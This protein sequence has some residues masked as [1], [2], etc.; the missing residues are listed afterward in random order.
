MNS[1]TFQIYNASAGSGKTFTLVKEYLKILFKSQFHDAYKNALAITFTNKAV[2]EMKDRIIEN[3]KMFSDP[4]ILNKPTQMFC[5]ICDELELKPKKVHLKAKKILESILHNYA[6]FDISTIDKFTQKLIRTFAYDLHL[7]VNFEVEL[8]TDNLLHKA[9]NNLI[10]KAGS[11][12]KL[13]KT[14]VDFAIEKADDDRSWDVSFD[15]YNIAKLLIQE[16][17][18]KYLE[19]LKDKTLQDFDTLKD[20]VLKKI[21]DTEK[22]I[23]SQSTAA[24]TL[25]EECG[26]EHSDFSRSSLPNHFLKLRS[27]NY[28]VKFDNKWQ[29]DLGEKP[30]YPS[31]VSPDIA[32][33]IDNIEPDLI[34]FFNNTK[35]QFFELLLAKSIYKNLTPLSV[36]KHINNELDIIKEEQNLLLISEFNSI[37]SNHIKEQP[38]PFIYERIGEKFKHYFIDEFQDTSQMQWENL[39]PLLENTLSSENGSTLI[40]GDAKQAIYRWRGGKAE[41]F[42]DLFTGANPFHIKKNVENLPANYR[43]SKNVV[44]FNN[45]FFNH[46]SEIAFRDESYSNLYQKSHQ[47]II[48]KEEGFVSLSFIETNDGEDKK[49]VYAQKTLSTINNCI[50]NGYALSDI[51]ILVRYGRDGVI[52]S[53]YLSEHGIEIISSET[54]L[55]KN[56]PEIIFIIHLLEYITEPENALAKIQA[57][58]YLAKHYLKLQ[59]KHDFFTQFR[60]SDLNSCFKKLENFGI[61]FDVNEFLSLPFYEA[62]EFIVYSFSLTKDSDSYIQFFLDFVLDFNENNNVTLHSFL[63]HYEL[64][65]DK[66]SVIS[67]EGNNAVQI[68]T[69]HK[70]KGLEFPVVIFPFADLDIYNNRKDKVWFPIDY[71]EFTRFE[72]ALIGFNDKIQHMG[73]QGKIIYNQLKAEKELDNLNLLYVA[74]T[75]AEEQLLII[76]NKD[77]NSKGHEKLNNYSGLFINYLKEKEIWDNANTTFE[78]GNPQKTSEL[79]SKNISRKLERFISTPKK[80]HNLNIATPSSFLWNTKQQEAIEKGNLIHLILSK[81][82]TKHDLP[83]VFEELIR[84]GRITKEQSDLLKPLVL[85]TIEHNRLSKYFNSEIKSYNEHDIISKSGK[86]I[87]PDKLV[88]LPKNQAILLD[89]KTGSH[90]NKYIEQLIEYQDIIEEMGLN[91]IKKILVYIND[92]IEIKEV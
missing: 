55:I 7:P 39:I 29:L 92:E 16:N 30:L 26:L 88:I 4:S 53:E 18:L 9:V 89:Y 13:T 56:S 5:F 24:L 48:Q 57:L 74:L 31:K 43:S 38:A 40:V 67:P 65:K 21:A 58:S 2:A 15:F 3:L 45:S 32:S 79:K 85:K 86:I 69:I 33:I 8:D 22:E 82:Y 25:I 64:K 35:T 34:A 84:K 14:L 49:E 66:L 19:T 28:T 37:I 11:E 80:Q 52:I 46:I 72:Y 61:Y 70:A 27:K 1:S 6:A 62:I 81:I 77:L 73:D 90:S 75:R 41:Q 71:N 63:E 83:F 60:D 78:F 54:L 17:D 91:V 10:A 51:C 42:I 68:M 23:I 47:N 50:E 59:N 76:S 44:E 36:L 87:R 20:K 12:K